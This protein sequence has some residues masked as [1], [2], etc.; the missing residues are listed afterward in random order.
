[1]STVVLTI[2]SEILSGHIL[3]TNT[4]WLAQRL[5]LLGEEVRCIVVL[6][7]SKDEIAGWVSR[8][9]GDADFLFVCGGLGATPDDVT[10]AAV[11][12]AAK[13]GL[14]VSDEALAHMGRLSDFLFEKGFIKTKMEVND[15]VKKMATVTEGAEV[16]EN[17]AGFCPGSTFMHG[18]T[19]I[20]VLPGV[21]QE[22]KTIFTDAI[23]GVY[24]KPKTGRYTE[25]LVLS[26]VEARIAH[27]LAKLGQDFPGVSIGSYPTYG[28]KT[29]VIRAMGQDED[30][31]KRVLAQIKEYAESL[32]EM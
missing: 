5:F 18:R 31:V 32:P 23:E 8:F 13:K 30:A 26:E 24:L 4:H 19:R 9:A 28:A 12:Q 21:P 27:L 29:L 11:A 2:G 25:E 20:F 22:L 14:V 3:D 7:D 17:K 15:A 1:M 6:P 10:T 16:L